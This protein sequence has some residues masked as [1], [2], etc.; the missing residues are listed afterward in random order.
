MANEEMILTWRFISNC[1]N[2]KWDINHRWSIKDRF[3]FYFYISSI[4]RKSLSF[5]R[6]REESSR[7]NRKKERRRGKETRF[8]PYKSI[9]NEFRVVLC[10]LKVR[11]EEFRG[12]PL[13]RGSKE[14]VWNT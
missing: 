7:E 4:V 13:R 3:G 6:E 11:F 9:R 8:C 1:N 5:G 2:W 10:S 12:A 14:T